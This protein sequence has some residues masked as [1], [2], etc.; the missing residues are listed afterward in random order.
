[1]ARPIRP[2]FRFYV[3][4]FPDR[5]L[6]RLT[7]TQRWV[8]VCVLGAARESPE[9]G[10][11]FIAHG[12]PMSRQELADYAGVRLREIGP[13]LD[14]MAALSM[15]EID[16]S[17]LVNVTNWHARQFE[18]DDVTKRTRE[19]RERS[20]ERSNDVPGN[21]PEIETETETERTMRKPDEG[22][23]EFWSLYPRKTAKGHAVKAWRAARK[24]A[25]TEVIMAGLQQQIPGI[26]NSDPKFI[27]H[28]A[29][30]L[31]GERWADETTATVAA[32]DA[33]GRVILPPLPGSFWG[34]R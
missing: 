1:M 7:P 11:L 33:E 8:W 3:E 28:P 24:K 20:G 31:N 27:P 9:S 22:F 16:A 17:G 5:K 13:A 29:T 4:S 6:R 30:W 25:P 32:T 26:S 34:D 23:E 14:A 12:V 15:I 2:W 21:A 10:S 19:H 18:S